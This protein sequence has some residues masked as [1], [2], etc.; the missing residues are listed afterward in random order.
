MA[1]L[2]D[3]ITFPLI[4]NGNDHPLGANNETYGEKKK[5]IGGLD[6]IL[7]FFFPPKVLKACQK[8]AASINN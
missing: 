8:G 4:V 2:Y 7:Y 1:R 6:D 5:K 3:Q